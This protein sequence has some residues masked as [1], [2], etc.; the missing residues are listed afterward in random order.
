MARVCWRVWCGFGVDCGY[1]LD[2]PIPAKTRALEFKEASAG[3]AQ[4]EAF[5]ASRV[6]TD[7]AA[8]NTCSVYNP[9]LKGYC[10][11]SFT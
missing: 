11:G 4:E 7:S 8:A 9:G 6:R 10:W 5:C 2:S 1:G 3:H